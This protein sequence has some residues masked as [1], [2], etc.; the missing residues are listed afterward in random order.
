MLSPVCLI[1]A[2][3]EAPIGNVG[4]VNSTHEQSILK[5]NKNSMKKRCELVF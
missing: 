3:G 1:W 5:Q 4:C 2:D